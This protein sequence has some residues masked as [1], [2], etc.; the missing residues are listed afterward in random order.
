MKIISILKQKRILFIISVLLF[1]LVI[2]VFLFPQKDSILPV[3]NIPDLQPNERAT[4]TD[5]LKLYRNEEWGFEFEYPEEKF[6][7]K[8]NAF[9]SYYS[10]FNLRILH[11]IGEAVERVVV[12]NVV[13]PEFAERSFSGLG[14]KTEEI[15][16]DGVSGIEYEYERWSGI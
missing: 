1:G 8:E 10:K 9:V 6:F 11:Q 15:V 5:G 13:L 14:E 4:D 3:N 2:T 12:V 16:V 7:I